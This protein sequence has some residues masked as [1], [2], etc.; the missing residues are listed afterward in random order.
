MVR[1]GILCNAKTILTM[2]LHILIPQT[3]TTLRLISSPFL[4][5]LVY[6]KYYSYA[7]AFFVLIIIT[8]SVDGILARKFNATSNFGAYYDSIADFAVVV[9]AFAAFSLDEIYPYWLLIIFTFLFVFFILTSKIY[10]LI[11]DTIGKYYGALLFTAIGISLIYPRY[12]IT[13][14]IQIFVIFI[15]ILTVI[16]RTYSLKKSRSL[17]Q[18]S[19]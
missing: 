9:S 11:Y 16:S 14:T 17:Y 6:E 3:I 1:F 5:F 4:F 8:D 13:L 2:N 12:P 18:K 15:T 10:D 19:S 7:F